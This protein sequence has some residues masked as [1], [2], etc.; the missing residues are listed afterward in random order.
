MYYRKLVTSVCP[1]KDSVLYGK[2]LKLGQN[3]KW[4]LRVFICPGLPLNMNPLFTCNCLCHRGIFLNNKYCML[5][6]L[7]WDCKFY[8]SAICLSSFFIFLKN[9]KHPPACSVLCLHNKWVYSVCCFKIMTC[10]MKAEVYKGSAK[11]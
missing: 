1:L 9:R 3:E 2:V 10:N 8:L 5:W 6:L 11:T 4:L 7:T